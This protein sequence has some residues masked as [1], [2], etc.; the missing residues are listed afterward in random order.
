[1]QSCLVNFKRNEDSGNN[2]IN[3]ISLV[4]RRLMSCLIS[5]NRFWSFREEQDKIKAPQ[6]IFPCFIWI[7]LV[8]SGTAFTVTLESKESEEEAC[9]SAKGSWGEGNNS[10]NN[11]NNK[12]NKK[13]ITQVSISNLTEA[14][15]FEINGFTC[16]TAHPLFLLY[17]SSSSKQECV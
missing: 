2:T 8:L 1:M 6:L 11:N 15:L 12:K 16:L 17:V 5:L 10:S 13:K 3:Y 14:K 7:Y 9:N 4:N